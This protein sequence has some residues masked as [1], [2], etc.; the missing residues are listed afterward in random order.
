MRLKRNVLLLATPLLLTAC[1]ES[2]NHYD[3]PTTSY[4]NPAI[5]NSVDQII[6]H[7]ASTAVAAQQ[8]TARIERTRTP[9]TV[10][11]PNAGAP[12]ELKEMVT[13]MNWSGPATSL[14]KALAD[15]VGYSYI[16]LAND[17][18]SPIMVNINIVNR[19]VAEA[20]DDISLQI[21]DQATIMVDAGKKTMQLRL[22]GPEAQ[23]LPGPGPGGHKPLGERT[24]RPSHRRVYHPSHNPS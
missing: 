12:P 8:M 5:N 15:K 10:T 19:T 11:D 22:K 7:E 4:E 18:Y 14:V 6:A 2:Y 1:S 9:P 21:Q 16:P 3:D 20:L 17:E 13:E 24:H 23:E